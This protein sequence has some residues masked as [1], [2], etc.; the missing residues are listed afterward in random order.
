[1]GAAVEGGDGGG[2]EEKISKGRGG[3]HNDV[4]KKEGAELGKRI[5]AGGFKWLL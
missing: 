3:M 1:M 4:M 2:E 5:R